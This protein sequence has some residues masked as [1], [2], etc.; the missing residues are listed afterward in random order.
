MFVVIQTATVCVL[1]L[2][3]LYVCPHHY[4]VIMSCL[5]PVMQYYIYGGHSYLDWRVKCK[6][7]ISVN[8]VAIQL[9]CLSVFE[10][11]RC[12]LNA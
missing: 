11:E 4:L 1:A 12:L 8:P 6:A 10:Q 9:I 3:C 5:R 7:N 2:V